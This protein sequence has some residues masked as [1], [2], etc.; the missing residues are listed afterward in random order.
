MSKDN[1]AADNEAVNMNPGSNSA[2]AEGCTCPI[3]DN[4]RGDETLGNTRG[5]WVS[6]DCPL[7]H[8]PEVEEEK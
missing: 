4:G 1:L 6:E 5:F 3:L 7:H 8:L 2:V